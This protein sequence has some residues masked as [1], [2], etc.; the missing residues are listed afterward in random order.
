M[1]WIISLILICVSLSSFAQEDMMTSLR[2][3]MDEQYLKGEY[4]KALTFALSMV[5]E[6]GEAYGKYDRRVGDALE[7]VGKLYLDLK[8]YATALQWY[9]RALGHRQANQGD[10]S[11]EVGRC[12]GF[13]AEVY[14][15][16]GEPLLAMG[17]LESAIR[18]LEAAGEPYLE[19]LAHPLEIKAALHYAQQQY[20]KSETLYKRVLRIEEDAYGLQSA[21]LAR[22]LNN[23]GGVYLAQGNYT[24]ARAMYVHALN[25]QRA[26]LGKDH[27]ET[28]TTLINLGVLYDQ[29][30]E[31][32]KAETHLLE[33]L[34][35]REQKLPLNH[36]LT[37]NTIDNLI[38]LYVSLANY[39]KAEQLLSSIRTEREE[40]YSPDGLP[41]AT[42]YDKY[43]SY[44]LARN[45]I[46]GAVAY[47]ERA[48]EIRES[49][50]GLRDDAVAANLYNIGRL[51]NIMGQHDKA[52][53]MLN[54]AFDIY[55]IAEPGD[56]GVIS[57]LLAE[58]VQTSLAQGRMETAEKDL[59]SLLYLKERVFGRFHPETVAVAEEMRKLYLRT[60]NEEGVAEMEKLLQNAR[61][62]R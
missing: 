7:T 34:E 2:K 47:M 42:V 3:S 23:I 25:M 17:Y 45:D 28:A 60:G 36:P 50:L 10:D 54:R 21:Q 13:I 9:T 6:A 41:L 11:P 57:A 48:L 61:D 46:P 1:R 56:Q 22:S 31:F 15:E 24:R 51:C 55:D 5:T 26:V 16:Q 20:D 53:I 19:W 38:T 43:A 35:V 8:E 40:T 27:P 59:N 62:A 32:D 14:L 58:L 33:A 30:G 12:Q 4:A 29:Q 44:H 49:H 52:R 18:T 39:D 37:G